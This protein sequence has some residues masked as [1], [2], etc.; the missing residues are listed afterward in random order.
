MKGKADM[1]LERYVIQELEK[2]GIYYGD[3]TIIKISKAFGIDVSYLEQSSRI[4][5]INNKYFIILDSRKNELS[6]HEEFLHVFAYFLLEIYNIDDYSYKELQIKH[7]VEI[8]K[9]PKNYLQ[10]FKR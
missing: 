1:G 3:L 8:L 9:C 7:I 2:R 5:K 6:Q 4:Y 10:K